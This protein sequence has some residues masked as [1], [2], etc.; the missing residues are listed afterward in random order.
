VYRS[1]GEDNFNTAVMFLHFCPL[2][3][4]IAQIFFSFIF[5]IALSIIPV[6]KLLNLPVQQ[7][8]LAGEE[9]ILLGKQLVVFWWDLVVQKA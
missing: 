5:F 6:V 1:P 3:A 4:F 7:G 8:K 2:P 9:E